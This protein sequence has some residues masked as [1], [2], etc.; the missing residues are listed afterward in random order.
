MTKTIFFVMTVILCGCYKPTVLLTLIFGL[1]PTFFCLLILKSE[2]LALCVGIFNLCGVL[3]FV[4]KSLNTDSIPLEHIF[5]YLF[6]LENLMVMYIPAAVG[7]FFAKFVSKLIV[8]VI[9]KHYEKKR[10]DLK[11]ELLKLVEIWGEDIKK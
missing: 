7:F 1:L 5:F 11:E 10:D 4:I 2:I 3:P 6:T 9:V 8:T